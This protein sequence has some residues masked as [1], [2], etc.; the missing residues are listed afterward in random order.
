MKRIEQWCPEVGQ[1]KIK[2]VETCWGA[3][4]GQRTVLQKLLL[5]LLLLQLDTIL[6]LQPTLSRR[7]FIRFLVL[8]ELGKESSNAT[9]VRSFAFFWRV[10]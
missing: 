4:T 6:A 9:N 8:L 1:V 3:L 10:V 5:S 2:V 7:V